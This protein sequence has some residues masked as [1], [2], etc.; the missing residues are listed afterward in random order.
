LALRVAKRYAKNSLDAEDVAQEAL[1]QAWRSR[2]KLRDPDR[3]AEW[4]GQI[5]KN[6]ALRRLERQLPTPV[7]EFE[8]RGEEDYRLHDLVE[9]AELQAA[10]FSLSEAD[11]EILGLRYVEDLTQPQVAVRLG[12]SETAAKVRLSRA[13]RK[14]AKRLSEV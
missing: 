7:E 11:Q 6:K 8:D 5:T 9:G 12:I 4:L 14:L 1:V 10:L 3:W 13:R 2:S